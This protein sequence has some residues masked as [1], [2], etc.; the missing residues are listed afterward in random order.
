M[1][2]VLIFGWLL[3]LSHILLLF[4]IG[5]SWWN[6]VIVLPRFMS[7]F[8]FCQFPE[9]N[10]KGSFWEHFLGFDR[11]MEGHDFLEAFLKWSEII[12]LIVMS[13]STSLFA[14][15]IRSWQYNLILF[16]FLLLFSLEILVIFIQMVSFNC[17]HHL[18]KLKPVLTFLYPVRWDVC[19]F[20]FGEDTWQHH[21]DYYGVFNQV[22]NLNEKYFQTFWS[23]FSQ[24]GELIK[25]LALANQ[26]LKCK[27]VLQL[28]KSN[29]E[30]T[31]ELRLLAN[32]LKEQA[33]KDLDVVKK[34][35]KNDQLIKRKTGE[36]ISAVYAKQFK[37][38]REAKNE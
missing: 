1:L 9:G 37:N 20:L 14:F 21:I 15:G 5:V 29:N 4:F 18:S 16:G 10:V 2:C 25:R 19:K 22:A 26:T 11:C 12:V 38:L 36:K 30:L 6:F 17:R 3:L 23:Q 27:G 24:H 8:V 32:D 13:V 7:Q 33:T 31:G 28:L 34:M 35:Q